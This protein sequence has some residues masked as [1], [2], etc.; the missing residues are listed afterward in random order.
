MALKIAITFLCSFANALSTTTTTATAMT[1]AAQQQ[2]QQRNVDKKRK[3]S[4][5]A[6]QSVWIIKTFGKNSQIIPF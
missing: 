2:K 5:F 1:T 4:C 3:K 6:F